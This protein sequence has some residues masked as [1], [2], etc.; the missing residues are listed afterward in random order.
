[1]KFPLYIIFSII[2]SVSASASSDEFVPPVPT[3]EQINYLNAYLPMIGDPFF[4]ENQQTEAFQVC[5]D[6]YFELYGDRS[7]FEAATIIMNPDYFGQPKRQALSDNNDAL[8]FNKKPIIRGS[9]YNPYTNKGKWTDEETKIMTEM[10]K[11]NHKTK[12]IREFKE[13]FYER[14]TR[15]I[16]SLYDKITDP[17]STGQ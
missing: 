15:H 10:K 11:L 6:L 17:G 1:M 3:N 12:C 9:R 14:T 7:I 2:I 5:N 8:I 4:T 13:I 16:A